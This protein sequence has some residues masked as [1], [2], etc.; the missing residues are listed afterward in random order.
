MGE[1]WGEG[2]RGFE[3]YALMA[4]RLMAY[5][6]QVLPWQRAC[7][8]GIESTH[9]LFSTTEPELGRRLSISSASAPVD[10]Y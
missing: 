5:S 2:S 3:E 10:S 7:V 1:E 9:A 6:R 4:L 8:H